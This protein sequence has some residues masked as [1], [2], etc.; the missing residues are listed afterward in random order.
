MESKGKV[1]KLLRA[2]FEEE[3]N[4]FYEANA[5]IFKA[6]DDNLNTNG[7]SGIFGRRYDNFNNRLK[8][9]IVDHF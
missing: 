5:D 2:A 7:D 9:Y 3:L 6:I 4:S 1:R 8:Q